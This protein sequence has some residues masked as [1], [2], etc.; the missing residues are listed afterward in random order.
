VGPD[1]DTRAARAARA[2]GTCRAARTH[3]SDWTCGAAG[4]G[5]PAR[6]AENLCR[7]RGQRDCAGQRFGADS[8]P[9]PARRA[10]QWRRS[11]EWRCARRVRDPVGSGGSTEWGN[12]HHVGSPVPEH[13][14][15]CGDGIC[16]RNVRFFAGRRAP[17]KRQQDAQRTCPETDYPFHSACRNGPLA[18]DSVCQDPK[19]GRPGAVSRP[20]PLRPDTLS[21]GCPVPDRT[22]RMTHTFKLER[23]DGTPADPPSFETTVLVWSPGRHD[24]VRTPPNAPRH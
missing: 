7:S 14:E 16:G 23:L 6:A 3:W 20:A 17:S 2:G 5:R 24:S 15:Y 22:D 19:R 21:L 9:V 4:T 8:F 13:D 10:S 18:A 1:W 11:S 12:G